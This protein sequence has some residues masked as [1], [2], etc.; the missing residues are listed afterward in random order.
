MIAP[1]QLRLFIAIAVPD[2]I[3]DA[4]EKA[5]TEL[6]GALPERCVRW[7]KREQFHLT[8]KFLGG[9]NAQRV[10]PL[11]EAVRGA[12][13]GFVALRLGA[14]RIGFFPDIRF[15]RVVWVGVNDPQEQL[16]RL[17][18]AV[19]AVTMDFRSESAADKFTGH[20]TLGRIKGIRR[21][22]A[23]S[24][25]R[26]GSQ[27]EERF[28]GEWTADQVEVIR[29]ELSPQGARYTSLAAIDLLPRD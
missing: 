12:C 10:D 9:V 28:L 22:E 4:M 21:T 29:S 18:R 8:L 1:D 20:V 19:D 6:R 23:E 15:P 25:A 17:Q 5:Q 26:L 16:P 27:M 11:I 13:G 3:K 2:E 14:R 7:A 24:L